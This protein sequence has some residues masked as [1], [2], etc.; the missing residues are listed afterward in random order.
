MDWLFGVNN[1]ASSKENLLAFVRCERVSNAAQGIVY[2][3]RFFPN[4]NSFGVF[5]HSK[6][7]GQNCFRT[8]CGF[9]G[10]IR[11]GPPKGSAEGSTK[12]SPRFHQ[13]CTS[14]VVSLV[15]SSG[16]SAIIVKVLGQNDTFFF[17][18]SSQQ[19]AFD[20]QKVLWSVPQTVLYIGLTVSCGFLG[21]WLLLLGGFC[22]LFFVF[23]SQMAVAS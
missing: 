22:Q 16:S 14:F 11:L 3:H 5:S 20:S 2:L 23:V 13:G 7:F 10:Q 19:M 17:W 4:S 18:G 1:K 9:V 8:R 15:F 12:V 6:G 21:K